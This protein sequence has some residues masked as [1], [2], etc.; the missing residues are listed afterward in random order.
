M[1]KVAKDFETQ[2]KVLYHKELE[3]HKLEFQVDFFK[4]LDF[5]E[6]EFH[7]KLKFYKLE[8]QKMVDC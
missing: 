1:K 8:F 6:L 3:F 7:V 5:R 4:K 2:A